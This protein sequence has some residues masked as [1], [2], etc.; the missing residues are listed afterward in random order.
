MIIG[1]INNIDREIALLSPILQRGLRY[2]A[3]TDFSKVESGRYE[4]EGEDMFALVSRYK[5]QVK[6]NCKAETH[7]KYIDIQFVASGEEIMGF[8][9]WCADNEILEDCSDS[10]D[11]I[12]YKSVKNESDAVLA[13]G[14][15]AILFPWDVHRPGCVSN[16]NDEVQKIV[17]KISIEKLDK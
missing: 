1:N 11:A 3:T 5:P 12:F 9:P 17:L 2:L 4:L 8:A 7:I 15:Y 13:P 14:T 10:R 6:A 16:N